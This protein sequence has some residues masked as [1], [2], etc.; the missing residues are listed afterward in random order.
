MPSY[1]AL[2]NLYPLWYIIFVFFVFTI[3]HL[4][5]LSYVQGVPKK[6]ISKCCCQLLLLAGSSAPKS[7]PWG[8]LAL[9]YSILVKIFGLQQHS[10]S[11]F[12]WG[13]PVY[14]CWW[15]GVLPKKQQASNPLLVKWA[16]QVTIFFKENQL[17]KPIHSKQC[18]INQNLQE[19]HHHYIFNRSLPGTYRP[20]LEKVVVGTN[21]ILKCFS[22]CSK[23]FS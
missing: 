3:E 23:E 10:E 11:Q 18:P 8:N 13:H 14:F 5:W 1:I 4:H 9:Q 20:N 12:F 21:F 6:W 17:E 2:V 19:K 15:E 16:C 7:C 22:T